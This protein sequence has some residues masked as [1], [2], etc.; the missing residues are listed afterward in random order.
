MPEI[1]IIARA[2]IINGN[3]ILLCHTPNDSPRYYFLPGGHVEIGERIEDALNRE[4][5]EE[6]GTEIVSPEFL[7][8]FEN[9]Y[10]Q[11][12]KNKHE[13]NFLY[14]TSLTSPNPENVK[15]QESHVFISWVEIDKLP[16]INLLP[17]T[18]RQFLIRDFFKK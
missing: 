6:I 7:G 18:I 1:E 11:E 16:T 12:E 2:V 9:F 10:S 8:F 13:I 15:S 14:K 17:E 5:K 3:E 4:M